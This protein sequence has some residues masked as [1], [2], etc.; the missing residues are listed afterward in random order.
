MSA[1]YQPEQSNRILSLAF[2]IFKVTNKVCLGIFT[3][4]DGSI[5]AFD[6]VMIAMQPVIEQFSIKSEAEHG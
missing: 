4:E 3:R 1:N 2:Q 5:E 6:E